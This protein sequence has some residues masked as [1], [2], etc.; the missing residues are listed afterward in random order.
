ML[1]ICASEA[2]TSNSHDPEELEPRGGGTNEGSCD[3]DFGLERS[4]GRVSNAARSRPAAFL[5]AYAALGSMRTDLAWAAFASSMFKTPSFKVALTLELS[6]SA[7]RLT[8]RR[9]SFAHR[10][11]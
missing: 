8:T 6:T 9:I 2:K 4:R 11:E 10:S 5:S 1:A 7:G 3:H